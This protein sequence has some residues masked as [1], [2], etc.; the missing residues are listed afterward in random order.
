[1]PSSEDR[2][3]CESCF[4]EIGI[5]SK[6]LLSFMFIGLVLGTLV[7]SM[8]VGQFRPAAV[9]LLAISGAVLGVSVPVVGSI[10]AQSI[11][12]YGIKQWLAH[13]AATY[14]LIGGLGLLCYT[15]ISPGDW[16]GWSRWLISGLFLAP[17]VTAVVGFFTQGATRSGR[18]I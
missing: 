6:R 14:L 12:E 8:G 9:F 13:S 7:G 15:M 18:A 4:R 5:S 17:L 11:K 16:T 2:K 1:M 3:K 10:C